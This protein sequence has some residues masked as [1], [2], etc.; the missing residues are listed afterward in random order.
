MPLRFSACMGLH[1]GQPITTA[2]AAHPGELGSWRRWTWMGAAGSR[3]GTKVERGRPSAPTLAHVPG[4]MCLCACACGTHDVCDE[5]Y[6]RY[7]A[8]VRCVRVSP[9]VIDSSTRCRSC[10]SHTRMVH[11]CRRRREPHFHRVLQ[12]LLVLCC[13]RC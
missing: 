9:N 10:K 7:V 1:G 5:S 8:C 6:A 3:R 12:P 4:I 11:V 13:C 2:L